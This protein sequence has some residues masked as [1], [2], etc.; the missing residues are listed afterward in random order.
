[1]RIIALIGYIGAIIAGLRI[2]IPFVISFFT[3][4]SPVGTGTGLDH[5]KETHLLP[6]IFLMSF[7]IALAIIK[8]QIW[9]SLREI[10]RE[11]NLHSPFSM[12]VANNIESISYIVLGL[13][14]VYFIADQYIHYVAKTIPDLN[15][16]LF[17]TDYQYLFSAGI[18]YVISQIFKRGVE[19]QEDNELTV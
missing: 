12:K 18:V 6:Y 5:I 14:I 19:L 15:Y 10:L 13:G 4:K 3:D 9:E 7:V 11:I 17:K 1:M 8:V 2:I 16:G